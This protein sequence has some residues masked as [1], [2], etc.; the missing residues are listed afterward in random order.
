MTAGALTFLNDLVLEEALKILVEWF[1]SVCLMRRSRVNV[2]K[3]KVMMFGSENG[4]RY[5]LE[6]QGDV[7]Q[8]PEFKSLGCK[9]ND[10]YRCG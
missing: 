9:V 5:D 7:E 2:T 3:G 10:G 4:T 1:Y 6:T 8:V